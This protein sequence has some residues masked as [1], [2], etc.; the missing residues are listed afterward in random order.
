MIR[1]PPRLTLT[2]TLFPYTTL[3]RSL[4][5]IGIERE[6]VHAVDL[7]GDHRKGSA[8]G[9][10]VAERVT[11]VGAVGEQADAGAA[12]GDEIGRGD[13][14]GRL[15]GGP[16]EDMGSAMRVYEAEDQR[17]IRSEERREGTERCC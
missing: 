17:A 1:R 14:V 7:V 2:D 10:I 3:F 12:L 16:V 6:A 5:G 4:V 15:A 8:S 9:E 11:I 13:D